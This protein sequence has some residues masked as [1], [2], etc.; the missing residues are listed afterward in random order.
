MADDITGEET[1]FHRP[2]RWNAL[3]DES[4]ANQYYSRSTNFFSFLESKTAIKWTQS[5]NKTLTSHGAA[6]MYG[7]ALCSSLRPAVPSL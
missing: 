6:R 4:E 5:R 2:P 3:R 7:L 1:P